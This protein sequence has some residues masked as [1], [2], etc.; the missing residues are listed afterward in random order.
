VNVD[1]LAA[2]PVAGAN[3]PRLSEQ[4]AGVATRSSGRQQLPT[5]VRT[6]W[7]VVG[8]IMGAA[9]GFVVVVLILVVVDAGSEGLALFGLIPAV[10]A[11]VAGW[12]IGTARWRGWTYELTTKWVTA[13]WGVLSRHTTTIPRN[14]VQ[15]VTTEAGPLDN[16]FGLISVKV[17]TAGV[18]D[19]R[20]PHVHKAS[21]DWL[22]AELGQ[23]VAG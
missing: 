2:P 5:Q 12:M 18:Q 15:S 19:L 23:G 22:K 21:V 7:Q 4:W 3:A 11:M 20:I 9:F 8:V 6:L 13:S 14:R 1:P 16:L 17:H 10:I